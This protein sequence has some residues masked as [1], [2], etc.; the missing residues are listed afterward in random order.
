MTTIACTIPEIRFGIQLKTISWATKLASDAISGAIKKVLAPFIVSSM[1]WF[2]WLLDKALVGGSLSDT[3]FDAEKEALKLSKKLNPETK[4]KLF[5]GFDDYDHILQ[6]MDRFSNGRN[7]LEK[8]IIWD[9][10]IEYFSR[11][12]IHLGETTCALR[13]LENEDQNGSA[14]LKSEITALISEVNFETLGYTN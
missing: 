9:Y 8:L 2:I 4:V 11:T 14:E 6:I 12:V 10:Q 13:F 5:Q 3:C 7:V 1:L